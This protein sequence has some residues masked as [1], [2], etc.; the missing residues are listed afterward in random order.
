MNVKEIL[1]EIACYTGCILFILIFV[2]CTGFLNASSKG[3]SHAAVVYVKSS[4]IEDLI[5]QEKS[6]RRKSVTSYKNYRPKIIPRSVLE[7][8]KNT[9][10]WGNIFSQN[11]K[12]VFYLYNTNDSFNSEILSFMSRN[13]LGVN[14]SVQAYLTENFKAMQN[15]SYGSSKICNS[16]EE[17]NAVRQKANDY[18]ILTNFLANCGKTMCIFDMN[19][20]QYLQLKTRDLKQAENMLLDLK[21]W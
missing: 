14:Y 1:K 16:L 19:K 17:C 3:F 13:N 10:L 6:T 7:G 20:N 4:G 21:N 18:S 15:G 2:H 11:R 5:N 8:A 9:Y 12:V